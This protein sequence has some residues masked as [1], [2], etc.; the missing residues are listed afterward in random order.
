[1]QVLQ[2]TLLRPGA[3]DAGGSCAVPSAPGVAGQDDL[4][5]AATSCC[6]PP[7]RQLLTVR[8]TRSPAGSCCG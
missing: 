6:T 2:H 1:M 8:A 5:E 7:A 3:Q 4:A